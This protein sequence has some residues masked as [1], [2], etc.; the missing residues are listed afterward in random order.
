MELMDSNQ[1]KHDFV[2]LIVFVFF[3]IGYLFT[4]PV[5]LS[6]SLS[7][8]LCISHQISSIAVF[9]NLFLILVVAIAPL[10]LFLLFTRCYINFD[11]I[12]LKCSRKW[13]KI[14]VDPFQGLIPVQNIKRS[15]SVQNPQRSHANF[16]FLP[17]NWLPHKLLLI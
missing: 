13:F 6:F 1:I 7:V 15:Y 5:S 2:F 10:R 9:I 17:R 3:F 8:S 14:R 4:M 11:E 16:E 12:L